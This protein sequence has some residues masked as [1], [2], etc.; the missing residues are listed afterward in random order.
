MSGMQASRAICGAP[1][2]VVGEDFLQV[3][4]HGLDGAP[5]PVRIL[6]EIV[7]FI[8]GG[9]VKI[10]QWLSGARDGKK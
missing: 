6:E 9:V 10:A 5:A 3:P 4:G 2:H 8:E 1:A 7:R